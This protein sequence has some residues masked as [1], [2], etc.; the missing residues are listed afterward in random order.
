MEKSKE[1]RRRAIEELT[2][3]ADD[4]AI[5]QEAM[6]ALFSQIGLRI[7]DIAPD[8]HCL[9]NAIAHQ[10]TILFNENVRLL[11]HALMQ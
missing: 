7:V 3:E 10:M 1:D 8:G 6:D 4:A 11:E 9:Y 2:N 5:E